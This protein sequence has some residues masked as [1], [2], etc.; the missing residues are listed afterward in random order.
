VEKGK[1][2]LWVCFAHLESN[3]IQSGAVCLRL[4]SD[5]K[6]SL[7]KLEIAVKSADGYIKMMRTNT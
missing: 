3:A 2:S 6:A 4:T 5:S 7:A 1:G